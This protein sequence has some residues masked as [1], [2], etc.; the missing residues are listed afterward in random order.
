MSAASAGPQTLGKQRDCINTLQVPQQTLR[1][2]MVVAGAPQE[3]AHGVVPVCCT[4]SCAACCRAA[5]DRSPV[6]PPAAILFSGALRYASTAVLAPSWEVTPIVLFQN[7]LRESLR[8]GAHTC[9]QT[10]T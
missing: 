9:E 1:S 5:L 8:R 2:D 6:P 4:R 3:E 7:E 10:T